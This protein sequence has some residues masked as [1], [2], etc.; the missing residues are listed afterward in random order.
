MADLKVTEKDVL[1]GGIPLYHVA[2]M[3]LCIAS[4]AVEPFT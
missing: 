1:I 3:Y 4:F 2:A